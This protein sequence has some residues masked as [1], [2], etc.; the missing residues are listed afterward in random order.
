MKETSVFSLGDPGTFDITDKTDP[1]YY[2]ARYAHEQSKNL[3][4][5]Q[6][7][8]FRW[9]QDEDSDVVDI[10]DAFE[11]FSS[12]LDDWF[13]TAVAASNDGLP[14]PAPPATPALPGKTI[15]DIVITIIWRIGIKILV[16]WLKKKLDPDTES[17]EI[18]QIL[19]K[20]LIGEAG[21]TEYSFIELLQNMP[22][23]IIITQGAEVQDINFDPM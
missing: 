23:E 7:A 20:G 17:K 10:R 6:Q 2:I 3:Y 5:L 16:N 18:A 4:D 9:E 15:T 8:S 14:V 11:T 22:L 13:V 19:K 12:D 1:L 21:G